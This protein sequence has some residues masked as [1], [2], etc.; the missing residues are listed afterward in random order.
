MIESFEADNLVSMVEI[1]VVSSERAWD[2]LDLTFY[3][4]GILCREQHLIQSLKKR[5]HVVD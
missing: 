3:N 2:L 1:K 4:Y 5:A